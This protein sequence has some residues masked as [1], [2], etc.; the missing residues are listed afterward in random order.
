MSD[1]RNFYSRFSSLKIPDKHVNTVVSLPEIGG[2]V[3]QR[4]LLGRRLASFSTRKREA[5]EKLFKSKLRY[6]IW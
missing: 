5:F 1:V 6:G 2:N 3:A 4:I